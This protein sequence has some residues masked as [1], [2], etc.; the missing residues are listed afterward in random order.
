MFQRFKDRLSEVS[1]EVKKDPR[2]QSSLHSVNS[3]AEK[4]LTAIKN[5]PV[6]PGLTSTNEG[7]FFVNLKKSFD[8][9]VGANKDTLNQ[10]CPLFVRFSNSLISIYPGSVGFVTTETQGH[11]QVCQA[12]RVRSL[13]N[14]QRTP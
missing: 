7:V 12:R 11:H 4:T 10:D 9:L 8:S 14:V 2:F 6:S 13:R 3:L 1:E 5:E